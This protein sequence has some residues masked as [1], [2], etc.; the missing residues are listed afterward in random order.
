MVNTSKI[1]NSGPLLACLALAGK[2]VSPRLLARFAA[3]NAHTQHA[4]RIPAGTHTYAVVYTRAPCITRP[5]TDPRPEEEKVKVFRKNDNLV[6]TYTYH[7]TGK[8]PPS[9]D[10]PTLKPCTCL[11]QILL[12]T[13]IYLVQRFT[14]VFVYLPLRKVW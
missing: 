2:K 8:I 11:V 4:P 3:C 7:C 6:H 1:E 10:L 5:R 12:W 9:F 13:N 14:E